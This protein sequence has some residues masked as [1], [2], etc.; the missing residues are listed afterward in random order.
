VVAVRI[1]AVDEHAGSTEAPH[2]RERHWL[3]V[4][5]KV[6]DLPGHVRSIRRPIIST[7]FPFQCSRPSA[8]I[9]KPS[10]SDVEIGRMVLGHSDLSMG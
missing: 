4:V 3:V 1:A 7:G 2:V 10:D 5:Q 9:P 8:S 6:W